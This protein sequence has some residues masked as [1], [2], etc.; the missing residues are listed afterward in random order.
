MMHD[1]ISTRIILQITDYFLLEIQEKIHKQLVLWEEEIHQT[2]NIN[3]E[4]SL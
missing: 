1:L 3:T 2:H 4:K